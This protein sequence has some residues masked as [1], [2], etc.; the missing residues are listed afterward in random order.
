MKS[1]TLIG[2]VDYEHFAVVKCLMGFSTPFHS[3]LIKAPRLSRSIF[4]GEPQSDESVSIIAVFRILR[5]EVE[6]TGCSPVMLKVS[7]ELQVG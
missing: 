2:Y 5:R 3:L 1:S 7:E 6:E 4:A